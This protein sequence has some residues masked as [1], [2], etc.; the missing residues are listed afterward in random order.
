MAATSRAPLD[1]LKW[2]DTIKKFKDQDYR[3]TSCLVCDTSHVLKWNKTLLTLKAP[4]T[5]AADD[6]C[7][8][9][10]NFRKK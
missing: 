3:M 7:Y 5:T 1:A 10:L 9:F 8:I 6:F 2:N 4:I